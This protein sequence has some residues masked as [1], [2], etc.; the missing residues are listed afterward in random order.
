MEQPHVEATPSLQHYLFSFGVSLLLWLLLA[1]SLNRQEII[2]GTLVALAVTWVA[3]SR[4]GVLT[5]VKLTPTAPYHL[6]RYLGYFIVALVRANL[7]MA[8][9][10]GP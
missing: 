10:G 7:D 1:G 2:T 8:R 6:I 3:G 9:R 5:G 4:L